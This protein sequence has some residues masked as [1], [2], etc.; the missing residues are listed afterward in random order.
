MYAQQQLFFEQPL[1]TII[2]LLVSML[3]SV[4]QIGSV[5]GFAGT[6][7]SPGELLHDSMANL[8]DLNKFNSNDVGGA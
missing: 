1:Q 7:K 8:Q 3:Q 4:V 2:G 5:V 6:K